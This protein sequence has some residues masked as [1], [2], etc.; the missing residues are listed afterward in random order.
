MVVGTKHGKHRQIAPAFSA[1]LGATVTAAAGV[2]TDRFGTFTGEV[3]RTLSP[4]DTAVAKARLAVAVSDIPYGLASEGSYERL[5]GQLARRLAVSCPACC[6]PGYGM[7]SAQLGMPCGA[8]GEP[9]ERV[10]V[11]I[12]GCAAC[13][14]TDAVRRRGSADPQWCPRCNP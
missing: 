6:A 5:A 8:C 10:L 3:P 7:I 12:V 2:D 9:T 14:H 13:A 4:R 1:V 11:D